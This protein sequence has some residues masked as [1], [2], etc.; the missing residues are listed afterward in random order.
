MSAPDDGPPLLVV[1]GPTASGK[2]ELAIRLAELSGGEI[3]S[4]DSVQ[5]YRRF[6]IGSG[7]PSAEE[8]ARAPQHLVDI[9]EP[10][11]P[12]EVARFVERA[13]DS[14]RFIE[15]R[16]KRP[17]LCGGTF[18]WVRAFLYGL[19]ESPPADSARRAEHQ[20][21]AEAEGRPALHTRLA[22]VDPESA[23]RLHPND[24]VRV[25]R[26]LEVFELTGQK[27]SSLQ[28]EHGFSRP[29][30]RARLVGIGHEREVLD[31]RIKARCAAMF[32]AGWVDEVRELERRGYG[33]CRAMGAVGYRHIRE[34]LAKGPF[35]AAALEDEVYRATRVFA[36]RQRTWLRDEP[37]TWLDPARLGDDALRALL[38]ETRS[39]ETN[40]RETSNEPRS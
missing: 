4:A 12:F 8:R 35:D 26:A 16:G 10:E 31:E 1:V 30:L 11:T 29:R 21:I 22:A 15:K 38:T 9:V 25:S 27:L 33:E 32:R 6:D 7:K 2:T 3:I 18:L 20:R 19:A 34:A 23:A 37:V 39:G 28:A 24:L 14:M 40:S 36:R 5:V 13:D 17:I